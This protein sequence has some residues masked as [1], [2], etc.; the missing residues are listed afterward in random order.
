LAGIRGAY[1]KGKI[2]FD[3]RKRGGKRLNVTA[4]D[5]KGNLLVGN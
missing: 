5:N 2:Y 1:Q 4:K 3:E